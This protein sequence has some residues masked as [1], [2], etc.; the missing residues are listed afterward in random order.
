RIAEAMVDASVDL[1]PLAPKGKLLTITTP[2]ALKYGVADLQADTLEELL[3]KLKLKG[4]TIVHPKVNWAEKIGRFLTGSIMSSI[5][6]SLGGLALLMGLYTGSIVALTIGI[7]CF[8]LFFFGHYVSN[9]AGYEE[10]IL[11]LLGVI[12]LVIEVAVI[13]GFGVVGVLGILFILIALVLS[14]SG[15]DIPTQWKTRV[16]GDGLLKVAISV[17]VTALLMFVFARYFPQTRAG[18]RLVLETALRSGEGFSTQ[19]AESARYLGM[20]G[21]AVTDLRPAGKIVLEGN[22]LDVISTSGFV[23]KETEVEVIEVSA[24][25]IVVRAVRG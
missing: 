18:R 17:S 11:L 15:L 25:R 10:L 7:S 12:L 14:S 23:S 21:I 20:R 4:A 9:L 16:I 22:K 5:L 24:S 13:P 6:M 1:P 19:D 8:A 2:D 3:T